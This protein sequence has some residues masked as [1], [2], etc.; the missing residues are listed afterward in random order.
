MGR[1][2]RRRAIVALA[3]ATTILAIS[4]ADYLIADGRIPDVPVS[5]CDRTLPTCNDAV[6]GELEDRITRAVELE[7]GLDDRSYIYMAALSLVALL[8]SA[9]AALNSSATSESAAM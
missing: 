6:N 9:A 4:F 3:A 5:D 8:F 7:A 2:R 1:D